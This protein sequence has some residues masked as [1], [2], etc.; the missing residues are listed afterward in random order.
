MTQQTSI[1]FKVISSPQLADIAVKGDTF[2]HSELNHNRSIIQFDPVIKSGVVRFEITN[3]RGVYGVGVSE[4][5]LIYKGNE[6]PDARGKGKFVYQHWSGAIHH[7]EDSWIEDNSSYGSGHHIA[8]ELNMDVIPRTLT[9]FYDSILQKNYVVNI[10][11]AMRFWVYLYNEGTSF[12]IT[13]F[14]RLSNP[15]ASQQQLDQQKKYEYGK[16]WVSDKVRD[17]STGNE[18]RIPRRRTKHIDS[19]QLE[20]KQQQPKKKLTEKEKKELEKEQKKREE[21]EQKIREKEE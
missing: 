14:E 15:S 8:M 17:F 7:T 11:P 10:P 13:K 19:E 1:S 21:E 18:G 6:E 2:T 9:F 20:E 12:Q 16:L 3:F 5:S 4:E